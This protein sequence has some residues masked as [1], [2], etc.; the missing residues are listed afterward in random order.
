MQWTLQCNHMNMFIFCRN[1]SFYWYDGYEILN[2]NIIYWIVLPHVIWPVGLLLDDSSRKQS[3]IF[4]LDNWWHIKKSNVHNHSSFRSPQILHHSYQQCWNFEPK[5]TLK[6]GLSIK[7]FG[8]I[9]LLLH[10]FDTEDFF[11]QNAVVR[12]S[13]TSGWG[14]LFA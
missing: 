11:P 7:A 14:F 5:L 2:L 6:L 12:Y 8:W 1:S 9:F 3:S 13:F 4:D 10:K